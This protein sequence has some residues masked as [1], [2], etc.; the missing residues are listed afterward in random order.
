[1]VHA[2]RSHRLMQQ[3]KQNTHISTLIPKTI[4]PLINQFCVCI[5]MRVCVCVN[6]YV[7]VYIYR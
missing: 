3:T 6:V 4:H 2:S 1:M 7:S 5:Y